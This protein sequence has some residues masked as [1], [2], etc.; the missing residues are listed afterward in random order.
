MIINNK[1]T[2]GIRGSAYTMKLRNRPKMLKGE[3]L[4]SYIFRLSKANYY[5][6]P[7]VM[8]NTIGTSWVDCHANIITLDSCELL[9]ELSDYT[10]QELYSAT[11]NSLGLLEEEPLIKMA[12][13]KTRIKY[14]SQCIKEEIHHQKQW[15]VNPVCICLKHSGLLIERCQG[16][17]QTIKIKNF[18]E[19]KCPNCKFDY[20][21]AQ[22]VA[23]DKE[24]LLFKS[25]SEV[26]DIF[27]DKQGGVFKGLSLVE[28]MYFIK[29]H[30][31]LL[32]GLISKA[33]E[34]KVAVEVITN[35]HKYFENVKFADAIANIY[36]IHSNFPKNFHIV[37]DEFFDL[38]FEVRRRRKRE[39][40]KI[41]AENGKKFEFIE[42]QYLS[43]HEQLISIGNVPKNLSSFNKV[44]SEIVKKDFLTKKQLRNDFNLTR[45]EVDELCSTSK[46]NVFRRGNITV[47]Q[48]RKNEIEKTVITFKAKRK[49]LISKKE[50]AD[51][52]GVHVDRITQLSDQQLLQEVKNYKQSFICNESLKTLLESFEIKVLKNVSE[53]YIS[54]QRLIEKYSTSGISIVRVIQ[55]LKD[56]KLTAFVQ[57]N[58]SKFPDYYF[59]K[60]EI[61][62][63]IDEFWEEKRSQVGYKLADVCKK[64]D[65]V[66]RTIHKLVQHGLLSPTKVTKSKNGRI[67]YFFNDKDIDDFADKFITVREASILYNIDQNKMRKIVYKEKLKNYLN[68]I[69]PKKILLH[70]ETV[71][72][73]MRKSYLPLSVEK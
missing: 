43:Y 10:S 67:I 21:K 17:H 19:G 52:L 63:F 61:G 3:S 30:L 73:I 23:V 64:L 70:K 25:Q 48:F 11:I 44:A 66:E 59:L 16:C 69:C 12:L 14:C 22:M 38:P 18:M 24:G 58:K 32:E 53:S 6:S 28:Y 4:S 42:K 68:N 5:S 41:L 7:D 46:L 62:A 2:N 1:E 54:F 56:N 35:Q 45:G 57:T 33:S 36:W 72:R 50:A 29:S 9:S 34:E 26:H 27:D 39:F 37:L 20:K 31:Y 8:A 51:I 13:L 60:E 49:N 40:E 47:Y 71:D 15:G 65:M 55:S